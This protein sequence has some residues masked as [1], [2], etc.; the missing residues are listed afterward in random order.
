M[1]YAVMVN[2][3]LM[4]VH[5]HIYSEYWSGLLSK[6]DFTGKQLRQCLDV[7]HRDIVSVWNIRNSSVGPFPHRTPIALIVSFAVPSER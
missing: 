6:T 1:L 5:D 4:F 7:I 3:V 2:L